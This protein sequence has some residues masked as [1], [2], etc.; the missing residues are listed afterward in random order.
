VR[1]DTDNPLFPR[2]RLWSQHHLVSIV[3]A[4]IVAVLTI[5]FT[6]N[7]PKQRGIAHR[8]PIGSASHGTAGRDGGLRFRVRSVRWRTRPGACLLL[9]A[10]TVSNVGPGPERF[11][12]RDQ[13]LCGSNGVPYRTGAGI[14]TDIAPG[15]TYGTTVEFAVPEGARPAVLELHETRSSK[16]VRIWVCAA[17]RTG[18]RRGRCRSSTGC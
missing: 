10:V 3:L 18:G 2:S 14:A 4:G 11:E 5:A 6:W 8:C 12:A 1:T 15:R 16:G 7:G 17:V 13:V 9:V